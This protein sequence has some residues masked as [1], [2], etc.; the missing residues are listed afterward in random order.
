[1]FRSRFL[2]LATG[3]AT[4]AT[5]VAAPPAAAAPA[6]DNAPIAGFTPRNATLQRK[7]EKAFGAV[8][9]ASKAR[10]LDRELASEPGL[11]ATTGDRRRVDRIVR[12]LRSYGLKPEVRTYYTYLSQPRR[13][14]VEMTAP[15][16]VDLPVKERR[17][18]WQ[19]DFQHVIPGHNGMSPDGRVEGE[20]VY[21][22]YGRPEDFALLEKSGISVKG[23]IV[24]ARYGAVFRGVK[25]REAARRG[26]RGVLI[27]S[28]PADDGFTRG[29]VYPEGPWRA[30]DGI[31]RGSVAQIMYAAGDPLT[32]GWPATRDARRIRPEQS[33]MLRGLVPTAP[34]SYGAAEPLLRSLKGAQAP[35]EWQGGLKL[36]YRFGPGGTRVHL[37]LRN[38]YRVRPIWNVIVRVPGAER[39]DQEVIVGAHHDS[40]TY[41]SV[42]NLSGTE[43]ILQIG[44]GLGALLKKGWKPRR[45]IVLATWDGEEYGLYGSSEYAE[46]RDRLLRN[47]VAYINMDG[48]GGSDFGAQATPALDRFVTDVTREVRWPGTTGTAYDDWK[49]KNRGTTPISRIGGGSDF[50]AFFQRYGVPAMDLGS[51]SPGTAGGYHCAC[52]DFH[53]TSRFGDPTFEYHAAMSRLVGIA[54]LR[55]A[56]ADVAPLRY[57][58]YAAETVTYL[59]DFTAAQR[60]K[61]GRVVVDVSRDVRQAR[62]WQRAAEALQARA[63]AA[64]KA[65]DTAAFRRLNDKIMQTE[66][67]L[68]TAAG[69]PRRPWYRHQMYAPGIDTGYAT[70]RLPALNDALFQFG[71]PALARRYEAELYRGLR[72]ATRTLTP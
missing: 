12:E 46:D 48:A 62:A 13:I 24:L 57:Q 61:Y 19:K 52:D 39:P 49:R 5:L 42:D 18:P 54:A 14:K 15:R 31:Q 36:P 45:S 28:D 9:T 51:S 63:D 37:D 23:K 69:L 17:R 38:D 25:P 26:A 47:A 70:Q 67:D 59:N 4:A 29:K 32:P 55:L 44:R 60:K 65:G 41:G 71:D 22:N 35:R 10:A 21:A 66:R 7:L 33:V 56:N 8:P 2:T 40:W 50:Q 6:T 43:N 34:I 20:V 1:M 72:A 27:Y 68:L 16:R 30:A 11:A 58:S 3:F 53:W 64:L